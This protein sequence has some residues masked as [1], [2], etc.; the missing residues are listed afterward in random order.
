MQCFACERQAQQRCPR[1]GNAFCNEHGDNLCDS[2]LDPMNAAPSRGVFRLALLGLLGGAVLSLWL[3]VR[4]P[5]VPG[6]ESSAISREPTASPALTPAGGGGG[7]TGSPTVT[8]LPGATTAAPSEGAA[9]PTPTAQPTEAPTQAPTDA[10]AGP[11]SYTVQ[12]GDTWFGIASAYG[13]DGA[14][15]AQYNG[16]TLDDFLQIGETILIPQ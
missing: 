15:L 10:P 3:L 8:P 1:C 14:T 6:D 9:S 16:R 2:C 4:P 7:G 5:G 13:I 11:I 12:D